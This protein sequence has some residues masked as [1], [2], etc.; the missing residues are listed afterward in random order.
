MCKIL[1]LLSTWSTGAFAYGLI[2]I[3]FRGY[4]HIS[5]G[6]LGGICFLI[7]GHINQNF[8]IG[9]QYLINFSFVLQL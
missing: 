1:K 8:L 9:F 7:I 6:I 4:T 2:E 5:M 3:L